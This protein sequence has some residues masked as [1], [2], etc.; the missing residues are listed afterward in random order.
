[1]KA[2]TVIFALAVTVLAGYFGGIPMAW[3]PS[4]IMWT[5]CCKAGRLRGI[6][7][8]RCAR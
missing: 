1:M 8:A 6:P 7:M 2:L 3:W 4:G 5:A